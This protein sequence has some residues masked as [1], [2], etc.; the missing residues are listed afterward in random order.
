[1]NIDNFKYKAIFAGEIS[2]ITARE[3]DKHISE[4]SL[5]QL[6]PLMP[7]NIDIDKNKDL[8]CIVANCAVAGRRN[9]NGDSITNKTAINIAKNFVHKY[10]NINHN[11]DLIKGCIVNYGF[12]R[13]STNEILTEEQAT[14]LQE[15]FNI[16]LAIVL[17]KTVLNDPFIELLEKSV[18][19][20]SDKF[21][22]LSV[23][24]EILFSDYDI[25]V[26][27]K[28]IYKAQ[29]ITAAEEKSDLERFLQINGGDGRK[30]D[31]YIYRVI[32]GENENDF[33]IP[34]GI[35]LVGNP[36]ADVKGIELVLNNP[37]SP[38]LTEIKSEIISSK[39]QNFTKDKNSVTITKKIN[40]KN[41]SM[42]INAISD[43]NDESIKEMKASTILDF[44]ND[45]VKEENQK[46]ISEQ[47]KAKNAEKSLADTQKELET[48]KADL[49]KLQDEAVAKASQETFNQRMTY[50]DDTYELSSDERKAIAEDI[51][52]EK[53]IDEDG[54]KKIQSKYDIFLKEKNKETI[55]A[56]K[57]EA[58]P[59]PFEKSGD[60]KDDK[61]PDGDGDDKKDEK[62]D[63]KKSKASD[64][65]K[66]NSALEAAIDN[67]K[68]ASAKIPNG[69]SPELSY[70]DRFA[71]AFK[72]SN[73]LVISGQ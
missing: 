39:L 4:A 7:N 52:V 28:D 47:E 41:N 42:K 18:N 36:A 45:K 22:S 69:G 12:S 31:G 29:L 34:A 43:I 67:G 27:S 6:I 59:N 26:G 37:K 66:D 20:K 48:I 68:D 62:K 13:F 58:K 8:V 33:I 32:K 10:C 11:K 38:E 61:E 19:P 56:K 63:K 71:E 17:W 55:A 64:D 25:A 15:P 5:K 35:G 46:F 51:A 21:G 57:K 14:Q 49:K 24:W 50:F 65:S 44:I 2:Q 70:A 23:S 30:D 54:F 3:I 1:M 40:I 9:A 53:S 60:K 73:C 16:S 72:P